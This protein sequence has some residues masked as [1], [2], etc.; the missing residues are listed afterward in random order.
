MRRFLASI[1]AAW[2][3]TSAADAST[4]SLELRSPQADQVVSLGG[5]VDWSIW[6]TVSPDDNR[7]LALV[8]VDLVQDADHNPAT[9]D[10]PPG[11][12]SSILPP[13]DQFSR[14]L[15][16]SNPGQHG[17]TT[18]YIGTQL[19]APGAMDLFQIGGAQNTLGAP[20]PPGLGEDYFVEGGIGQSGPV[21]VVSGQMTLPDDPAAVGTY[22]FLLADGFAN[23]LIEVHEPPLFSPV[24]PALV[25]L[26]ARSI[27]ITMVPEPSTAVI[28]VFA[29][30]LLRRR[31]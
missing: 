18:G 7:G 9:F 6:V 31:R 3:L 12:E 21:L 4:V 23:T 25:D 14:P 27:S 13:M 1:T 24:E 11:F 5:V 2:F 17:A 16:I 15:G 30:S 8:G 28:L 22:T 20:G 10:I 19:G 29:V 26:G